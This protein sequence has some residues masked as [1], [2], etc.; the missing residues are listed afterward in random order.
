M[1]DVVVKFYYEEVLNLSQRL[2]SKMQ[3]LTEKAMEQI[4]KDHLTTFTHHLLVCDPSLVPKFMRQIKI[5][6]DMNSDLEMLTEKL[7]MLA[8][9]T[10]CNEQKVS[11]FI[12]WNESSVL[13]E[14]KKFLKQGFFNSTFDKWFHKVTF[15]FQVF[16]CIHL[17]FS[18]L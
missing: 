13:K 3:T 7:Q 5:H 11:W 17:A 16:L 10:I 15:Q 12:Q 4:K 14:V 9:T 18:Q 8:L 2:A 1:V 6:Y